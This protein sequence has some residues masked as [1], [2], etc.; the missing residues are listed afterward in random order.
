MVL[1][2]PSLGSWLKRQLSAKLYNSLSTQELQIQL[3]YLPRYAKVFT[4]KNGKFKILEAVFIVI[5]SVQSSK[6]TKLAFIT[7]VRSL[8][9]VHVKHFVHNK[10]VPRR[11]LTLL[12]TGVNYPTYRPSKVFRIQIYTCLLSK[13]EQKM[14]N[15]LASKYSL[16]L[17]QATRIQF[18]VTFWQTKVHF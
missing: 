5:P 1:S 18:S 13:S 7:S 12:Q 9:T 10:H 6:T 14:I 4:A 2:S 16:T 17:L 11:V 15:L 3:Y 8:S